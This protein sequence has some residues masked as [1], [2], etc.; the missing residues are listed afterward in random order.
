MGVDRRRFLLLAAGTPVLLRSRPGFAARPLL[1]LATCDAEAQIAVVDVANGRVVKS[2]PCLR[3]PRSIERLAL[4]DALV[5]HWAIGAVS[6]LDGP[7][8]TVRRVL[9]G[10]AEPRYTAAHPD[11]RHAFVTDAGPSEV[12]SVDL[13]R[14]EILGRARLG[15]RARHIS[16]DPAGRTLWVGLGSKSEHVAVVD[17]SAAARPR[18]V[19]KVRPP[20]LAHDVGVAPDGRHAWVTSG[21]RGAMAVYDRAGKVR[22]RLPAD[23]GPQHVSFGDGVAYVTSGNAGTLRVLSLRDGRQLRATTVPTGSFNVQAGYGWVLTPSLS[24]GT[25]CVLD[26]SGGVIHE[27]AVASSSHDACFR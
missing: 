10:F 11:G 16:I 8:L 21:D 23:A 3:D 1:A 24:R 22:L 25:L 18:L 9:R 5:C 2:I 14:G 15:E 27:V 26:R 4:G 20:F 7:S 6:I 17:V 12:V 19:R 13:L